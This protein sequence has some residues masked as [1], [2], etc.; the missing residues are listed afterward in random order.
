MYLSFSPKRVAGGLAFDRVTAGLHHS[1]GETTRNQAY[2]WGANYA[3][4]LGDGSVTQR[5]T[6]VAVAGGHAFAELSAGYQHTC[7]KTPAGAGYC[8]GDNSSGQLGEGTTGGQS[9][10]PVAVAGP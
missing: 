3:G 10:T 5:L 9:S 6:P 7:G 8:W 4:Q 1:C 2:C